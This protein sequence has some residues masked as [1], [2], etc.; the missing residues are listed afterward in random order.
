M[1]D[2]SMRIPAPPGFK[3]IVE[4]WVDANKEVVKVCHGFTC[5]KRKSK[6]L[7]QV[8]KT[9]FAG[10]PVQVIPCP[11]TGNCRKANNIIVNREVLH[12][13]SPER[14]TDNVGRELDKQRKAKASDTSGGMSVEEADNLLGL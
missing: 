11:C 10:T 8:L 7:L 13:Q 6:S 5:S 2:D 12:M 1:T 14:V 9:K 3:P 4:P